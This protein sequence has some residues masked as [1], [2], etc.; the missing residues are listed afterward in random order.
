MIER[1]SR[2]WQQITFLFYEIRLIVSGRWWRWFTC[3]FSSSTTVVMSYRLDRCGYLIFKEAW[4]VGRIL[5]LPLF[6]FLRILG[7]NHDIHYRANIGKGLRIL[8]PVLGVVVNGYAVIG[9]ELI[10]TGGNC[11]GGRQTL[12]QDTLRIG[13]S[14]TLGAN[15]VILG[16]V[17]LGN[18]IS[19]GAGAVV[20]DSYPEGMVLV[21]VPAKP[22][23][24]NNLGESKEHAIF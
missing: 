23:S 2:A 4:A 8:H 17:I 24:K 18:N 13:D 9:Q 12:T 1:L 14:V 5:F 3:W 20:I 22:L 21:G 7:A 10:L 16:P 6:I 15:A 19:I 11:I